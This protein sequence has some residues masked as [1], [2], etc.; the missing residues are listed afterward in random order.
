M[1]GVAWQCESNAPRCNAACFP[2]F[3]GGSILQPQTVHQTRRATAVQ[4]A[5]ST[6]PASVTTASVSI[7]TAGVAQAQHRTAPPP[8]VKPSA[9]QQKTTAAQQKAAIQQKTTQQQKLVA[10]QQPKATSVLQRTQSLATT[11]SAAVAT[12]PQ[13]VTVQRAVSLDSGDVTEAMVV[14]GTSLVQTTA[15]KTVSASGLSRDSLSTQRRGLYRC[16][17]KVAK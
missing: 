12:Q 16:E 11:T 17:S 9:A 14:P 2:V 13:K 6:S 4:K 3:A 1:G 10:Q 8:Q 7:A 15:G 5:Q